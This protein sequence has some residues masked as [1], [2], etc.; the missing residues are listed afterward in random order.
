[1]KVPR[2]PYSRST[3]STKSR[4]LGSE[5]SKRRLRAARL[6]PGQV[7]M[8]RLAPLAASSI[9]RSRAEVRS[10]QPPVGATAWTTQAVTPAGRGMVSFSHSIPG[11][12]T[13]SGRPAPSRTSTSAAGQAFGPLPGKSTFRVG[14][15]SG[16]TGATSRR[17]MNGSTSSAFTDAAPWPP[18]NETL[19][20]PRS[21]S[22]AKPA[23]ADT[24]S[25]ARDRGMVLA[26]VIRGWRRR[27]A[28]Q[29]FGNV[30][31]GKNREFAGVP[32]AR[33]AAVRERG[34][35]AAF[36]GIGVAFPPAIRYKP[37]AVALRNPISLPV[38]ERLPVSGLRESYRPAT[39]PRTVAIP[40]LITAILAGL[41]AFYLRNWDDPFPARLGDTESPVDSEAGD[42]PAE[43]APVPEPAEAEIVLDRS[44]PLATPVDVV[45]ADFTPWMS[46]L[47]LDTYLRQKNRGHHSSLWSR[48]HWIRAVEGRWRDGAHEFRIALGAMN[49]PGELQWLYRF[50]LTEIAFAEELARLGDKGFVLRQSQAYRHPDGT[51][52]YQAV[53][54]RNAEA[55]AEVAERRTATVP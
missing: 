42:I 43:V 44:L 46:P 20:P 23:A 17:N 37:L 55:E 32:Q 28:C 36:S 29:R 8:R 54:Q 22:C 19:T 13:A 53:W 12:L 24:T 40:L 30:S 50:D 39:G 26:K 38:Y 11:R 4:W 49:R 3:G 27:I 21:G 52:R 35:P 14:D 9:K 15:A 25:S 51:R 16:E 34:E 6:P 7:A 45:E 5:S 31:S 2:R 10:G 47:A 33:D 48:G 41:L 1:M 18:S